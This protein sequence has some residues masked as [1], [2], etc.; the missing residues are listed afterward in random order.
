MENVF[1]ECDLDEY[2]LRGVAMTE[3]LFHLHAI[4]VLDYWQVT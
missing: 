2:D 1:R 3:L 4:V